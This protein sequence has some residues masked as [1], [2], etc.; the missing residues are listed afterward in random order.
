MPAGFLV[1]F[2]LVVVVIAVCATLL[3]K[4]TRYEP[5]PSKPV[6]VQIVVLGDIGHSPRMQYHALSIAKHGGQVSIVGYQGLIQAA[7]M[8]SKSYADG[9]RAES[10]PNQEL[11]QHERISIVALPP[12]PAFLRTSNKYLFPF[13][14]A[15][16]LANQTWYLWSA[17]AYRS[18]PSRWMLVQVS[19][20]IARYLS[21]LLF[22]MDGLLMWTRILRRHRH[23]SWPSWRAGCAT[24]A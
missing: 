13:L 22:N 19:R 8:T 18:P 4:P 21:S 17:L 15:L 20:L 24:P 14:A 5:R 3:L 6:S 2:V 10:T 16:K 11:L 23:W 12:A 7:N 1:V 9:L